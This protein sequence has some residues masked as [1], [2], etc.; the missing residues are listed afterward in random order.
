MAKGIAKSDK[1]QFRYGRVNMPQALRGPTGVAFQFWSYPI[2]QLEFLGKLWKE[3]PA[4]FFAWVAVS[5][6]ANKSTQE[7]LGTD[8]SSALGLGVNWGQLVTL[9]DNI[10][11]GADA[12]QILYQLRKIP[13]G[14]GIFPYGL[15]PGIQAGVEVSKLATDLLSGADIDAGDV[16]KPVLPVFMARAAQTTEALRLG[17]DKQGKYTIKS[18]VTG[19]PTYR[20]SGADLV[21]RIAFGKPVSETK[22]QLETKLRVFEQKSYNDL[23]TEI[24]DLYAKGETKEAFEL[25]A[26]YK[27][28]PT[29]ESIRAAFERRAMTA[30]ERAKA[31]K[32]SKARSQYEKHIREG[33]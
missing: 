11:N 33:K 5:E 8:L 31:K 7:F 14:G 18:T 13:S 3:N 1:T 16:F 2:K 32:P 29:K 23:V 26:K 6:G 27:I 21:K 30:T 22:A 17:Q 12:K 24:S 20:E 19:R 28:R 25:M 15:G 9:V 4:K 10:A